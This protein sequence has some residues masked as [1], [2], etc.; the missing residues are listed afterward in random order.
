VLPVT[1]TVKTVDAEGYVARTHDRTSLRAVQ[2]PQGFSREL[3]VR[4][5]AAGDDA[6]DDAGLVEALGVRVRTV[7]GDLAS[8]KITTPDD[9]V[10]AEARRASR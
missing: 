3:L 5:H 8:A 4:A 7:V 6:T 2:T 9:L 1:D 10:A